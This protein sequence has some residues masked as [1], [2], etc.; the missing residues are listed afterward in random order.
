M[1]IKLASYFL[2][3][4]IT[5]QPDGPRIPELSLGAFAHGTR[6]KQCYLLFLLSSLYCLIGVV[7]RGSQNAYVV[8][9]EVESAKAA[10][11]HN[12]AEVSYTPS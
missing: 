8:F 1:L 4:V 2:C 5:E 10:L 11:A 6:H 9:E 12:M 7:G 3:N